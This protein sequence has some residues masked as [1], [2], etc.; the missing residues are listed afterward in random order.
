[1]ELF[2][3][4]CD[5]LGKKEEG[6]TPSKKGNTSKASKK[7]DADIPL[8]IYREADQL[9]IIKRIRDELNAIA[10]VFQEQEV[11]WKQMKEI[12]QKQMKPLATIQQLLSDTKKMD[13]RAERA[14]IA[15]G[16]FKLLVCD[17]R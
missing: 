10:M 16:T 5:Y 15:V 9:K 7:R 2:N 6:N 1:M 17:V 12:T 3:D 4:F 13:D 8:A 11:V 14:Q